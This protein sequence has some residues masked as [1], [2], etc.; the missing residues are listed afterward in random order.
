[1]RHSIESEPATFD[2][3]EHKARDRPAAAYLGVLDVPPDTIVQGR[4]GPQAVLR[5]PGPIE[6]LIGQLRHLR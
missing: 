4:F 5:V 1:L 2:L 6:R 3:L